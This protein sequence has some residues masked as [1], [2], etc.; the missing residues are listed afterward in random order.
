MKEAE[1]LIEETVRAVDGLI[2]TENP[3]EKKLVARLEIT[4]TKSQMEA[5]KKYME[6]NGITYARL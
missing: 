5:M 2:V 3:A 6:M 1:K 4:A